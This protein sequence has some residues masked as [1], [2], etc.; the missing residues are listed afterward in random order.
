MK[1]EETLSNSFSDVSIILKPKL[2]TD[3]QIKL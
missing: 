3:N 2:D 1:K